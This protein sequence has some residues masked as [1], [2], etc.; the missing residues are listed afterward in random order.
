MNTISMKTLLEALAALEVAHKA[1]AKTGPQ[2][3]YMQVLEA[4][5]NLLVALRHL[6]PV[7]VKA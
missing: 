2:S 1:L 5:S 4:R 6:A 7:E 3:E